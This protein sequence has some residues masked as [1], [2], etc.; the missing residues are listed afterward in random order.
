MGLHKAVLVHCLLNG[1]FLFSSFLPYKI[2][3]SKEQFS[4]FFNQSYLFVGKDSFINLFPGLQSRTVKIYCSAL[5][6]ESYFFDMFPSK[7][8]F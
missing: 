1:D 5:D 8:K 2:V 7:S 4:F 3:F 6:S